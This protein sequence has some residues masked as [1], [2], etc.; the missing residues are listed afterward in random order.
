VYIYSS[1]IYTGIPDSVNRELPN[2]NY[3]LSN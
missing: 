3:T 2:Y 1:V